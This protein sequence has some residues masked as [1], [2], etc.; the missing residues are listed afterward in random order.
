[1]LAPQTAHLY[2]RMLVLKL[3]QKIVIL[4]PFFRSMTSLG[5]PVKI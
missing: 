3:L 4:E 2:V 1:M 5:I